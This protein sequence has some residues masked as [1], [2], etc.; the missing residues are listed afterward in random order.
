[1]HL[2]VAWGPLQVPG[3]LPLTHR[4]THRRLPLTFRH[5]S[6]SLSLACFFP[7]SRAVEIKLGVNGI[8]RDQVLSPALAAV[9]GYSLEFLEVQ[10]ICHLL[11]RQAACVGQQFAQKNHG[12]RA[13]WAPEELAKEKFHH[14]IVVLDLLD[15]QMLRAP[16]LVHH[17][18]PALALQLELVLDQQMLRMPSLVLQLILALDL[19]LPPNKGLFVFPQGGLEVQWSL[20]A[21]D[22]LMMRPDHVR[23]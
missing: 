11:V 16:S 13:P 1:M 15:Q 18:R 7:L 2:T 19:E 4:Q 6:A 14:L 10:S 12:H 3:T 23:A 17:L 20:V 8:L 9:L 5:C 21:A 22:P